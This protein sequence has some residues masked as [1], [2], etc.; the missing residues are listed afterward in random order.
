MEVVSKQKQELAESQTGLQLWSPNSRLISTLSTDEIKI[1]ELKYASLPFVKMDEE[2]RRFHAKALMAK[3]HV[4]VGWVIP[5]ND[6]RAILA[7]QL[8]MKLVE[9]YPHVN[10]QEVEYAFRKNTGVQDWG[11]TMNLAL[12][13]EVMLPYLDKRR[14]ISMIEERLSVPET[15]ELPPPPLSEEEVMD[16]AEGAWTKTKNYAFIPNRAYDILYKQGKIKLTDE[17]RSRIKK[18]VKVKLDTMLQE[19]KNLFDSVP[20]S[21]MELRLCKKCAVAEYF[22]SKKNAG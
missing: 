11:K 13:D 3:I 8:Q 20:R 14:D 1:L 6:L 7:D 18:I 12:I 16:L 15:K 9:S 10:H 19:D 17:E 21:H 2:T 5:D 4:I 22:E